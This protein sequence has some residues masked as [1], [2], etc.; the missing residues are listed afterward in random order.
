MLKE[1][2]LP[3]LDIKDR[4]KIKRAKGYEAHAKKTRRDYDLEK[5]A[6]FFINHL[7]ELDDISSDYTAL[8]I[9]N[10]EG[11]NVS[12]ELK[13]RYGLTNFRICN[14]GGIQELVE[15]P[16]RL[17]QINLIH[18]VLP[19]NDCFSLIRYL[20]DIPYLSDTET[21]VALGMYGGSYDPDFEYNRRVLN[22]LFRN[23]DFY[24]YEEEIVSGTS[25]KLI[26]SNYQKNMR[27]KH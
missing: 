6:S 1:E 11:F 26:M 22:S 4:S 25:L 18:A 12:S 17:K 13:K 3:Q 10:D 16:T 24:D 27:M 23:L 15:N 9:A 5:Y 19:M 2:I 14:I 8:E 7:G 20:A 21:R